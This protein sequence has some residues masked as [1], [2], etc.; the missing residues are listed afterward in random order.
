[1][2]RKG[3]ESPITEKVSFRLPKDLVNWIRHQ[4]KR[5]KRSDSKQVQVG[6]RFYQLYMEGGADSE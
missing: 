2:S 5:N 4:A 6:L 1:M 3:Y